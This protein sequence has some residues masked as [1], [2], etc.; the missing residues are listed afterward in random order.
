MDSPPY[1][2]YHEERDQVLQ[3]LNDQLPQLK[4]HEGG[5]RSKVLL[6]AS[7]GVVVTLGSEVDP[8]FLLGDKQLGTGG[9]PPAETGER[10]GSGFLSWNVGCIVPQPGGSVHRARKKPASTFSLSASWPPCCEPL[11]SSRP[12][13]S[14]WTETS[15]SVSWNLFFLSWICYSKR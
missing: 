12:T 5:N 8:V 4:W 1:L 15:E 2:V 14:W 9:D 11:G 3:G 13:P 6:D 10:Q 7:R